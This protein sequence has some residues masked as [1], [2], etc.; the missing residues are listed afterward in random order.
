MALSPSE[1]FADL[2]K[3]HCGKLKGA[4]LLFTHKL[5]HEILG[6]L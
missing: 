3:K 6:H 2:R 4:M 1:Y 5:L